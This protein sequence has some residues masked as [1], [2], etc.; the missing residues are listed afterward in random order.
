MLRK[1][2]ALCLVGLFLVMS[3]VVAED[4]IGPY[5][6]IAD[7]NKDGVVDIMDLVEVGQAYGSNYTLMHQAN[8]TTVTV[9]SFENDNFSYVEDALVAIFTP[10]A[11]EEYALYSY[12]DSSGTAA[13]QLSPNSTYVAI[14]WNTTRNAYN[15]ASFTTNLLGEAS[16]AIWLN[17]YP[18]SSPIRSIPQGW[19]VI[20]ILDNS[21]GRLAS[22]TGVDWFEWLGERFT[23]NA[24]HEQVSWNGSSAFFDTFESSVIKAENT[25]WLNAPLTNFACYLGD[26]H[27]QYQS[28]NFTYRTDEFGG[29]YVTPVLSR[30]P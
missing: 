9:L 7:I 16:V 21:T 28:G 6:P 10:G 11:S 18:Q 20:L 2:V 24:L 5:N 3:F 27:G 17:Y 8:K 15:Y 13:F 1:F 14:A 22:L 4:S 26:Y 25:Y 12:T 30:N 29:A 23:A 19:L